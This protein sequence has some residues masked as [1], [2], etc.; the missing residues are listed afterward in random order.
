MGKEGIA[1]ENSLILSALAGGFLFAGLEIVRSHF[2]DNSNP[3]TPV[4]DER[5]AI[6]TFKHKLFEDTEY[7]RLFPEFKEPLSLYQGIFKDPFMHPILGILR[8]LDRLCLLETCLSTKQ[9]APDSEDDK[10]LLNKYMTLIRRNVADLNRVID[11]QVTINLDPMQVKQ[12]KDAGETIINLAREHVTAVVKL[13][14]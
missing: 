12:I 9:I 11:T 13:L 4:K 6:Q 1:G 7:V 10:Q 2:F 3:S 8:N 14:A 5:G